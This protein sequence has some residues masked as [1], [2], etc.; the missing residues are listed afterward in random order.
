MF[1]AKHPL[2]LPPGSVRAILALMV[3][4]GWLGS[5]IWGAD[6]AGID[7][8]AGAVVAYYFKTRESQTN[9]KA[10]A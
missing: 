1:D 9:E 10:S 8:L 5:K 2:G 3:V 4:G 7:A 6:I